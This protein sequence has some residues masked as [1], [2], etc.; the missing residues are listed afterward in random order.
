MY[1]EVVPINNDSD[2][3]TNDNLLVTSNLQPTT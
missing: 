1:L 2:N 3:N